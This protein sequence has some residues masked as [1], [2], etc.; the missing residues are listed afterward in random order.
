MIINTHQS[1]PV[2]DP[3]WDYHRFSEYTWPQLFNPRT[4]FEV[5]EAVMGEPCYV[6]PATLAPHYQG[7]DLQKGYLASRCIARKTGKPKI[8]LDLDIEAMRTTQYPA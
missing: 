5:V 2:H 8:T 4:G 6:V 1:W 7:L 3:P